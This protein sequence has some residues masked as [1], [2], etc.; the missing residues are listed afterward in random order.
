MRAAADAAGG[1]QD[2]LFFKRPGM[3]IT[4]WH[5]DA[6]LTPLDTN[7]FITFWI[8]LRPMKAENDSGLLF[9]RGS[10]RDMAGMCWQGQA[11]D[12]SQ[13]GYALHAT[14]GAGLLPVFAR[15]DLILRKTCRSHRHAT[16][17]LLFPY[18]ALPGCS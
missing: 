15:K 13:R 4:N 17:R 12:F 7:D 18:Q 1:M 3:N 14:G 10:H 16:C 5:S 2:C 8:P 11:A 9:A 6:R